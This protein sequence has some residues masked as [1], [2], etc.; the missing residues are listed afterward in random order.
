MLQ[1]RRSILDPFSRELFPSSIYGEGCAFY[2]PLHQEDMQGTT[3]LSYDQNHS[4]LTVTGATWGIQGRSF[5]AANN[6]YISANSL[7]TTL[8]QSTIGAVG[9]WFKSADNAGTPQIFTASNNASAALTEL[10]IFLD[11][12]ND[13]F[14]AVL[15]KDG[16]NTAW[17]LIGGTDSFDAY[18]NVWTHFVV[19]QD[20]VAPYVFINGQSYS[21]T[22]NQTA[23]KTL[24]FKATFTDATA[25]ANVAQ[26]G[27]LR[28]NG[29]LVAPFNGTIGELWIINGRVPT[30]GEILRNYQATRWRYV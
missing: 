21:I 16:D 24:W 10:L 9:G 22:F 5:T 3:L 13:L 18:D 26:L 20:G 7:V 2:A 29:T 11:W 19:V 12:G 28:R 23:D 30:A 17:R 15:R 14:T 27:I 6:D 4:A 25:K 1:T 8:A